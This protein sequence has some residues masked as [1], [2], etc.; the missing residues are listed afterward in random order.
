MFKHNLRLIY[1]SFVRFKSTFLINLFGLSTGLACVLFIYLWVTDEL[2]VD[3]FQQGDASLLQVMARHESVNGI[4]VGMEM[5][6]VL[7]DVLKNEMPEV[8]YAVMEARIPGKYTLS[9]DN[10]FLKEEGMYAG[11]DY[12]HVFS[13]ALIQGDKTNVL[14]DENSIAISVPLALRLFNTTEN[15]IGKMITLQDKGDV[16][17]SGVFTVP[18]SSSYQFDFILPFDLQ[19]KHYPNLK[20]NWSSNWSNA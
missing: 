2:N 14:K 19:F 3:K 18:V 8:D 15:V 20:N 10:K 9:V 6:P 16:L 7:G 1:R 11:K 13:Y 5:A 12:F 4:D 17:V